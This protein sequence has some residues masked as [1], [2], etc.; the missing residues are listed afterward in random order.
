MRLVNCFVCLLQET[1]IDDDDDDDDDD[2]DDDDDDDDDEPIPLIS[3]KRTA[4]QFG[5]IFDNVV[6]LL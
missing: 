1:T 5:D 4:R 3:A 2:E 6:T